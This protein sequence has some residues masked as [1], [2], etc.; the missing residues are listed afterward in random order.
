MHDVLI[1]KLVKLNV[2]VRFLEQ[3]KIEK[4]SGDKMKQII[5]IKNG[6]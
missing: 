6:I 4:I 5:K 1:A 2:Y 3:G